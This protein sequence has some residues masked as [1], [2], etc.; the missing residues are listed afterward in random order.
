MLIR[1]VRGDVAIVIDLN[2]GNSCLGIALGQRLLQESLIDSD[3][4]ILI[5]SKLLQLGQLKE[6]NGK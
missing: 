6:W 1:T 3:Q 2:G 5:I 4:I